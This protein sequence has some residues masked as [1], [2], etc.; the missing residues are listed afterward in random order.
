MTYDSD[1]CY[2]QLFIFPLPVKQAGGKK[3]EKRQKRLKKDFFFV[4][5]TT[6]GE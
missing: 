3:K 2:K 1:T 4:A 6:R 5:K